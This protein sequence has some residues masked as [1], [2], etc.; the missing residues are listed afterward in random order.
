[1]LPIEFSIRYSA[2]DGY[3][4]AALALAR[5]LFAVYD[6]GIDSLSLIPGGEERFALYFN[7]RLV[8]SQQRDGRLPTVADVRDL[9]SREGI[10]VVRRPGPEEGAES[11]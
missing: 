3:E 2:A 7:G 6:T 11:A 10:T 9:F 1:M 5:R 4:D 8:T